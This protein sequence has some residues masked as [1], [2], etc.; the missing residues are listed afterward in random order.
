MANDPETSGPEETIDAD[1]EP[2]PAADYVMSPKDARGSGPGWLPVGVIGAL[3]IGALGLSLTTLSGGSGASGASTAEISKDIADLRAEL[4]EKD[5]RLEKI[6]DASR[7]AEEKLAA[8]MDALLTGDDETG[9]L[10]ALVNELD[11]VSKRLDE[12][13]L[14]SLDPGQI[15]AMEAR[16][17]ELELADEGE[18]LG[19]RQVNR[20]LTALRNR[21]TELETQNENLLSQLQARDEALEE[22]T[23]R[24][25]NM[26]SA[27]PNI[28]DG[29]LPEHAD[30][31]EN[32]QEQ[33]ANLQVTVERGEDIGLE[34]EKRFADM[35]KDLQS[36][37]AAEDQVYRAETAAAAALAV[38]RIEAAAREG[39]PFLAAYKQLADAMPDDASVESLKPFASEGAPTVAS[40]I[41]SFSDDRDAALEAHNETTDDG[42]G[43]TRQVFGNGVK[44]RKAGEAGGPNELLDIAEDALEEGNLAKAIEAVEGLPEDSQS[45]MGEWMMDTRNRIILEEALED[46]GVK[47]IGQER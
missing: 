32:L 12:A 31:L 19:S 16:L 9:G 36:V 7:I 8:Q 23:T 11:S 6:S 44:V 25:T 3:S 41:R 29:S 28:A 5:K 15:E 1:F 10:L 40:L 43:W 47:L 21:V 27:V 4:E 35:L 46:I 45:V 14:G 2:A 22:V 34:N 20:A 18:P 39:R 37:G 38:S 42:W 33:M 13:S 26:E 24:I 30:L 17:S